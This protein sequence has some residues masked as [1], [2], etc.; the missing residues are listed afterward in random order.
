MIQQS[1]NEFLSI[2]W[3]LQYSI[4]NADELCVA[5]GCSTLPHTKVLCNDHLAHLPRASK[6]PFSLL[7]KPTC[8][9]RLS[10]KWADTPS[11]HPWEPLVE[12]LFQPSSHCT[13]TG[14]LLISPLHCKYLESRVEF[15]PL[16]SVHFALCHLPLYLLGFH[17]W[18]TPAP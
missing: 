18:V 12:I 15:A 6:I 3:Q 11:F 16:S 5:L 4:Y 2:L 7:I 10:I 13:A 17:L 8:S 9:P 14:S 1:P